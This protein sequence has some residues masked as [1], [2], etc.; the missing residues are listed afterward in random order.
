VADQEQGFRLNALD[1]VISTI[2]P[3][4][5]LRRIKARFN[6]H[7]AMAVLPYIQPS[8]KG[9]R[10]DSAV[11]K[12]WRVRGGSPQSDHEPVQQSLRARSR[13]LVRN[14]P[15]ASSAS[16]TATTHIVGT[17]LRLQS[18]IDGDV[19][20]L[21]PEAVAEKQRELERFWAYQKSRLDYE[22]SEPFAVLQ[23]VAFRGTFES[24]DVLAVR[25]SDP[26]PEDLIGLKVQLVE[27]DRISDPRNMT[28]RDNLLNILLY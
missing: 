7:R 12:N 13:D 15:V 20:G 14:S 2:S 1:R 22:G 5:G 21:S 17:G 16:N 10:T 9:A 8:Y 19:V 18:K 28:F 6:E 11:T 26:Q 23:A 24:G 25:R 4:W 3:E 27:A